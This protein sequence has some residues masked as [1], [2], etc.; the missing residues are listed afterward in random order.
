MYMMYEANTEKKLKQL[1]ET[2]VNNSVN[3]TSLQNLTNTFL[4]KVADFAV[5]CLIHS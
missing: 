1:L 5:F 4:D 2:L 3:I